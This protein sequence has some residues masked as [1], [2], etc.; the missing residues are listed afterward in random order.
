V[1]SQLSTQLPPAEANCA[2]G[3][4]GESENRWEITLG[5]M[6]DSW[7]NHGSPSKMIWFKLIS[8]D[9]MRH[10]TQANLPL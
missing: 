2:W 5:V 6:H 7:H 1:T 9:L 8:L 3:A 10:V 4:V